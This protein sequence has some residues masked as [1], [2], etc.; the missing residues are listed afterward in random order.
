MTM[1]ISEKKDYKVV[2]ELTPDQARTAMDALEL[3]ARLRIGQFE[4]ITDSV[5]D[6]KNIEDYCMRR[7]AANDLMKVL[8]RIIYGKDGLGIPV[9]KK[10]E[11][12]YR[13]WNIYAAIRYH[14][15]W[16]EHPEGGFGV[17]FDKPY[18]YGEEPVPECRIVSADE[19]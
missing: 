12:H 6:F 15:A 4:R 16:H 11:L 18:P 13:A 8:K 1:S 7:D 14:V 17:H 19:G 2:L 10:D 9:I 3:Y 5:L